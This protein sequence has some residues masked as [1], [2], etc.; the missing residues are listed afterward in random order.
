MISRALP[1]VVLSM[2]LVVGLA[3]SAIAAWRSCDWWGFALNLGTELVGAAVTYYLF[4]QVVGRREQQ[5]KEREAERQRLEDEKARLIAE[6]GSSVRDV[7]IAAAEKLRQ[8]GWLEDGSLSGAY[9]PE[10]DLREA[11]LYK[12]DLSKADLQRAKLGGA[13]CARPNWGGPCTAK[14]RNGLK[15]LT[16]KHKERSSWNIPAKVRVPGHLKWC[17]RCGQGNRFVCVA[18]RIYTRQRESPDHR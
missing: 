16:R 18:G 3:L 17:G 7:A 2:L 6:M 1:I 12:A 8:R 11:K 9:L 15:S 10:A 5:E 4:G 14:I 13:T